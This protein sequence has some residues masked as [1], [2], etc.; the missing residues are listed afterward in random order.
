[1]VQNFILLEYENTINGQWIPVVLKESG[2]FKTMTAVHPVTQHHIPEEG[3]PRNN[4]L[5]FPTVHPSHLC[6]IINYRP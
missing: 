3:N 1:M 4:R 5:L 2:V 6:H